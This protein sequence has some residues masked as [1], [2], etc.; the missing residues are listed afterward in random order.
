MSNDS[1][2]VIV[3]IPAHYDFTFSTMQ[4]S[5]WVTDMIISSELTVIKAEY[6]D[7]DL[8]AEAA[9]FKKDAWNLKNA[10]SLLHVAG[11]KVIYT[12]YPAVGTTSA[13]CSGVVLF[14]CE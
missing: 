13:E 6:D 2:A 5:E 11:R 1:V 3:R 12:P 10:T 8:P 4:G 7:K 9:D 14:L